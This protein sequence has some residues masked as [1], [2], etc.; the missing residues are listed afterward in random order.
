MVLWMW[1]F[2]DQVKQSGSGWELNRIY[3][4]FAIWSRRRWQ[5]TEITTHPCSRSGARSRIQQKQNI[6]GTRSWR[7][8][9][10]KSPWRVCGCLSKFQQVLSFHK[11]INDTKYFALS[12]DYSKSASQAAQRDAVRTGS[13]QVGETRLW[14]WLPLIGHINTTTGSSHWLLIIFSDLLSGVRLAVCGRWGDWAH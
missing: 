9:S 6:S 3:S 8:V 10:P 12:G 2:L 7:I 1:L 5:Q 11:D 13:F 14:C 4:Q